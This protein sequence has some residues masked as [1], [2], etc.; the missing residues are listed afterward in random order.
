MT[1][2]KPS[3]RAWTVLIPAHNEEKTIRAVVEG[4][5]AHVD[6]VLVVNDGSIDGTVA[7]LAGLPVKIV[8]HAENRGKGYR[9]AQGLEHAFSLGAEA[10]LTLDAD[11][12][13]DP[14]D[15]PA[16]IAAAHMA[17][18]CLVMGD[19][20]ADQTS[21]PE[22]RAASIRFG[23]FFISWASGRKIRDGQCGMRLYPARLW[24]QTQIPEAERAHFVFETAVLLRAAEAG[25]A[26]VRVPIKARYLGFVLRPSHFR[27][28]IDTLRIVRTITK[29][30]IARGMKL[31][32][33]LIAIGALR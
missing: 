10:V 4:A 1:A 16:F 33:L 20:F 21:M 17:P 9:L 30:L 12:Q 18:D 11:G 28:V 3:R 23:D 15:I 27:P 5:L 25:F 14:N 26:I 19:R 7:A 6:R 2:D 31:R 24:R 8:D 32:G 13:H 29:F 22:G